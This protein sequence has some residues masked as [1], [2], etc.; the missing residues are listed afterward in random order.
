MKIFRI[1][2]RLNVGGPARHVVWLTKELQDSEFQSV[3]VAGTIPEG[4][5]DMSYFAAEHGVEP[6]YIAELSRELSAND[7]FALAK[8]YRQI[9]LE[10]AR[11]YSHAHG[12]S[13][14]GR[15]QAAFIYRWLTWGT[16]IGKPRPVRIVHT[17]HG[18]V[19]HSYYGK[20]KTRAF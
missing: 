1:I 17:F 11:H 10:K 6:V 12:K 16:L 9:K 4:E 18:H 8:I 19:F 15:S 13:G 7:I 2:A 5:A 14:N 3:L 20:F